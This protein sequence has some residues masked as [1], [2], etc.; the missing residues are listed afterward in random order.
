MNGNFFILIEYQIDEDS[1][2][3]ESDYKICFKTF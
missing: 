2:I 3:I 1:V